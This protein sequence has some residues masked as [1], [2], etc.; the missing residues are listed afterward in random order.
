MVKLR[1]KQ[2]KY[3]KRLINKDIPTIQ[4]GKDGTTN[5]LVKH[6]D[7]VLEHNELVRIKILDTE[8][9]PVKETAGELSQITNSVVIRTIG[10]KIILY[11]ESKTLEEK[12]KINLPS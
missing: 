6:L 8:S 2:K 3:L 9:Y 1:A 11:R 7:E 12:E 10:K 4:V 5:N